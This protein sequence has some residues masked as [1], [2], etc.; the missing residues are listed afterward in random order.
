MNFLMAVIRTA[1]LI[2]KVSR[3]QHDSFKIITHTEAKL[4]IVASN[5]RAA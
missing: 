3:F 1:M 5:P 4:V 2:L